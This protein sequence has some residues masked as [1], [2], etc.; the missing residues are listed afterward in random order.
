KPRGLVWQMLQGGVYESPR[1]VLILPGNVV[2]ARAVAGPRTASAARES[3]A[4][5]ERMGPSEVDVELGEEEVA[6]R[7]V[8]GREDGV[9]ADV[10]VRG[11]EPEHP[12]PQPVELG[13]PTPGGGEAGGGRDV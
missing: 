12:S 7:P 2:S 1:C 3:E 13:Q 5:R 9:E 11:A 8:R 10:G 6:Q 4:R